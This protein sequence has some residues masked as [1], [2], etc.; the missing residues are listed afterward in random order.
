MTAPFLITLLNGEQQPIFFDEIHR[1]RKDILWYYDENAGEST[2]I[3]LPENLMQLDYWKYLTLDFTEEWA[4]SEKYRDLCISGCLAILN[5]I[6]LEILYEPVTTIRKTWRTIP[7]TDILVFLRN[8][9][10]KFAKWKMAK[11]HLIRTYEFIESWTESDV[12]EDGFLRTFNYSDM[13]EWFDREL[14]QAYFTD[15]S[16]SFSP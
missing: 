3:L 11:T 14:V 8:F 15:K 10:P 5:G 9:Q 13:A 16:Q 1:L 4:E 7:A 2:H 6:A 12:D